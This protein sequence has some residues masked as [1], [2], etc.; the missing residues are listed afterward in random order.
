MEVRSSENA[1]A[2]SA[3]IDPQETIRAA[4]DAVPYPSHAY[5]ETHPDHLASI[6]TLFGMKPLPVENCRVLEIGC[7]DGSNL[8]PMAIGLPKSH[9]VGIDLAPKPLQK[10]IQTIDRI[11]IT[12]ITFFLR[13]LLDVTPAFG[14]FDYIVANGVYSWTP[15]AVREKLLAVC[16]ENLAPNG[17]AFVSYNTYPAGH[18]RNASRE[19]IQFHLERDQAPN[20]VQE[21]KEFLNFVARSVEGNDLWKS[22]LENELL[23][24]NKRSSNATYH[25]DL[26]PVY[27][28]VYF[29]DFMKTAA[30]HGLQFLSEA[31]THDAI[32]SP[33]RPEVSQALRNIAG[34]DIIAYQQYLDFVTCGGLRRTLLCHRE[35]PLRRDNPADHLADLWVSSPLNKAQQSADA[36]V[37]FANSRGPGFVQTGAPAMIALLSNLADIWPHGERFEALQNRAVAG[38]T[39]ESRGQAARAVAEGILKLAQSALVDLR[40]HAVG[41]A[42]TISSRP[43][44]SP[45]ARIQAGEGQVVTTLSHHHV[46]LTDSHARGLLQLLDGVRDLTVLTQSMNLQYP[47]AQW[48]K[49]RVTTMLGQFYRMGLLAA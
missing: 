23:R 14:Q 44:A 27:A 2:V 28:P 36:A 20:G 22:V 7:G 24:L 19:I 13:D 1:T 11:G 9:F 21:G 49:E 43:L 16:S 32:G 42:K 37:T 33:V 4:Y 18:I 46:Q 40:T 45:L 15:P 39:S 30:N 38:L 47:G 26:S 17:V 41:F 6:S 35:V 3:Q 5:R 12:N 31:R 8:I 48:T 34:E 10:A 25:D 29:H